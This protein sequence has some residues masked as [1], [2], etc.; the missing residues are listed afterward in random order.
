MDPRDGCNRVSW[1]KDRANVKMDIY[2]RTRHRISVSSEGGVVRCQPA[3]GGSG[4]SDR[5]TVMMTT[6]TTTDHDD[7]TK[8]SE[9]LFSGA[10]HIQ[11]SKYTDSA[12]SKYSPKSIEK[13]SFLLPGTL[14]IH[15]DVVRESETSE[16]SAISNASQ[17]RQGRRRYMV[18]EGA[19]ASFLSCLLSEQMKENR[20]PDLFWELP[21]S[22]PLGHSTAGQLQ[23]LMVG[24]PGLAVF[25]LI[26]NII[27]YLHMI[28]RR[29][30]L[31]H[32]VQ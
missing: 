21:P 2:G 16:D 15:V 26:I 14:L 24:K 20:H 11:S 31:T 5:T 4:D 3:L 19:A 13:A 27:R 30:A 32:G 22:I 6:T 18:T 28:G 17:N 8:S 1:G 12:A 9:R 25:V 29:Q 7:E 10:R 23:L